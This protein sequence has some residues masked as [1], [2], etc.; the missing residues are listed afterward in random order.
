MKS[1]INS[2]STASMVLSSSFIMWV[3]SFSWFL[4]GWTLEKPDV[5]IYLPNLIGFGLASIQML[6]FVIYP[7][8]KGS[9]NSVKN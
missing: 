2:K 7:S 9:G 4:Y 8:K 1:V 6:L 3:N 5:M